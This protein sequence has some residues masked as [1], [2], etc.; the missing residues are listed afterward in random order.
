MGK[1]IALS[2]ALPASL[3]KNYVR[4]LWNGNLDKDQK[5]RLKT[6]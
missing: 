6:L 2:T 3:G 5:T 4:H 1:P